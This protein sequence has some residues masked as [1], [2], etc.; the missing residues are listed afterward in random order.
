MKN[1]GRNEPCPCGSGRKFK[2]CCLTGPAVSDGR[3]SRE[4]RASALAKLERFVAE[5]MGAEDE[6]AFEEFWGE[7]PEWEEE[8]GPERREESWAVYDLWFAFDREVDDGRLVVDLFLDRHPQ[9]PAGERRFLT[10]LR[11]SS[12]RLYEITEASPGLSVTLRDV[13]EGTEVTVHER[14]ASRTM[15]RHEWL[16]ARVVPSGASGQPEIEAGVLHVPRL[17]RDSVLAQL[18]AMR[19]DFRRGHPRVPVDHFYKQ[20]PPFFH[21]A[22]TTSIL[23]PP[24]PE[25]RNTD[26]EAMVLSRVTFDVL[27]LD[28]LIQALSGHDALEREESVWHW[29]G[30]N[31]RGE[32]VSLGLFRLEGTRLVLETNSVQR[33]ERGRALLELVAAGRVRH[34]ATSHEELR[35]RLREELR[36][37]TRAGGGDAATDPTPDFVPADVNE[38]LVLNHLA[39]HYRTWLDE[40]I[41]ALDGR[42]PRDAAREDALRPKLVDLVRGLEGTYQ[43]ALRSGEP[44]YDPSWM[45]S[46]L[47]LDDRAGP[48]HPPPLAHERVAALVPGS[49]ELSRAA[50]EQLRRAPGFEDTSTLMSA[51]AFGRHLELQR[52]VREHERAAAGRAGVADDA[53]S[54]V[55]GLLHLM[56]NFELHRRKSFWV[57]E[58]LA[59]TLDQTDLDVFGRELRPPFPAFALVFTDRH[60]LSL[61]ERAIARGPA[62][63]VRGHLLRVV[64]VFVTED[65]TGDGRTLDVAFALDTLGADLPHVM[66]HTLRLEDDA[67]VE[68]YLDH[69]A[70]RPAVEPALPD[71]NPLRALLR[72]TINA[73]LYA[74]SAGVQPEVRR[75]PSE[76]GHPPR[77]G[78][79]PVAH[80]AD[81]VYFLPGVI[82]ISQVRRMQ[83]LHRIPD[84]HAMLRRFMVRGHWRR[85]PPRWADQRVR[86][87]KPYWKGPDMA[88]IIERTYRLKP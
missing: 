58:S 84:G 38:A 30:T 28:A 5:T 2:K 67:K 54:G 75:S 17:I 61:A 31:Q 60:V 8:L 56:V 88:A 24:V 76:A 15:Q 36:A 37:G 9:L 44:A 86:W 51:E 53:R 87:I 68:A 40:P 26:G 27:D 77:R 72:V 25:L 71:S 69:V 22:W 48:P 14:T 39:R 81:A 47:G 66:R 74:T 4:D 45:W 12:M 23:D 57:D 6:L 13:V 10:A 78:A 43:A 64:T 41:P 49:G 7:H 65:S 20:L 19:E 42:T 79:A 29:S 73:I 34:R 35:R 21:G 1:P 55:V 82:E 62:S 33:A 46:E 52:F 83:E 18:S 80:S 11:G 3:Y 59:Y 16:A 63:P 85:A 50:A 70:P 32:P